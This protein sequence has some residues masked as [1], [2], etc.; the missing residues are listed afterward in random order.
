M[1]VLSAIRAAANLGA[2]SPSDSAL[3]LRAS[4]FSGVAERLLHPSG[5]TWRPLQLLADVDRRDP[6]FFTFRAQPIGAQAGGA[7]LRVARC[8]LHEAL[9]ENAARGPAG[10]AY[11]F[12]PGSGARKGDVFLFFRTGEAETW[13]GLALEGAQL[14]QLLALAETVKPLQKTLEPGELFRTPGTVPLLGRNPLLQDT[15]LFEELTGAFRTPDAG[16]SA[17][18]EEARALAAAVLAGQRQRGPSAGKLGDELVGTF[19][20]S[21][22]SDGLT[23]WVDSH[24]DDDGSF[25]LTQYLGR[26]CSLPPEIF[27]PRHGNPVPMSYAREMPLRNLRIEGIDDGLST[28]VLGHDLRWLGARAERSM[29]WTDEGA[30]HSV[31][32]TDLVR[33]LVEGKTAPGPLDIGRPVRRV[34]RAA[35]EPIGAPN[36]ASP[37]AIR[38]T[39]SQRYYG[40][41]ADRLVGTPAREVHPWGTVSSS[42]EDILMRL[43]SVEDYY[44]P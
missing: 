12:V 35:L 29:S 31:T 1:G 9:Q 30:L 33:P 15:T 43:P 34:N 24:W 7:P 3:S 5:D 16:A 42:H 44:V 25:G 26:D 22:P 17:L 13:A 39:H 21:A 18:D 32:T 10:G 6:A 20:L 19:E 11:Y 4:L 37:Q 40:P 14:R 23:S 28:Q 41:E 36:G 2:A 27:T 38:F 8:Y